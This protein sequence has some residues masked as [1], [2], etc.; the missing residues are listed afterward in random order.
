MIVSR[1]KLLFALI[2]ILFVFLSCDILRDSTYEVVAWTPGE[3]FHDDP[4]SIT[5]SLLLSHESD[6]VRTE[7]A[8]SLVGDKKT[9]SGVYT[10]EGFR[11]N[12]NPAYPLEAGR[13]YVITLGTGAQDT[14]GLS[15]EKKFEVTF[16]TRLPG[17]KPVITGTEPSNEGNVS[18]SRGGF[19]IMFSEPVPLGSCIDFISFFPSTS[20]SW[21]LEDGCRAASFTPRD[22]WQAGVLYRVNVD[23]GFAG[24]SGDILGSDYITFFS[25]VDDMDKPVLE[26]AN[27][28]FTA[29]EISVTSEEIAIE[30]ILPGMSGHFSLDEFSGWES[31]TRLELVFS[32]P[33]DLGSLRNLLATEPLVSLIMESEPVFSDRAIFRFAE[34]PQWGSAFL[35][36]LSSGIKDINGNVSDDEYL[37]RI[38]CNGSLSKPPVLAGIRLPMA[39]GNSVGEYDPK[40]Y[41]P[42]DLFKDLPIKTG[43]DHFPYGE[44]VPTWIELY[45]ET[46]PETYIDLFSLMEFFRVDATNQALTF[47]P[48]SIRTENF[49]WAEPASGWENFQR[50]EVYGL[51]TNST[52]SGIVSF[53]VLSGL[54]DK[55]GNRSGTDF[56]I[57][58]LK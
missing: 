10:W 58:L 34:I 46:A 17:A 49:I 19:R 12:F 47:S 28:L 7:Q 23:S 56:R 30:R 55:R 41:S 29:G 43:E 39:P 8:F 36:R 32:K 57:S 24:I 6:R 35:F 26:S 1:Q 21:R 3:G 20:G 11:L 44:A 53:R 16:T 40:T 14:R 22:P 5:I 52:N 51:L 9:I 45:F 4:S 54:R 27:A 31:Y 25:L 48:L 37:F 33:V 18:G 50:I 13:D 2:M 42:A 38:N 15:L